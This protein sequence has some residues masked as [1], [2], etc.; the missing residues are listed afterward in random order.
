MPG[1]VGGYTGGAPGARSSAGVGRSSIS[2]SSSSAK[3]R[4]TR[5]GGERGS[6]VRGCLERSQRG[7]TEYVTERCHRVCHREVSQ[8]GVTDSMS[9]GGVTYVTRH[10]HRVRATCPPPGSSCR[11]SCRG[12]PRRGPR[13]GARGRRAGAAVTR[14]RPGA[15]CPG[16]TPG[17]CTRRRGT[18]ATQRCRPAP[19]GEG[20][21]KANRGYGSGVEDV[22]TA[23]QRG[24]VC[25]YPEQGTPTRCKT[26]P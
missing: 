25:R 5:G 20:R 15:P 3:P 9:Q 24:Q 4:G 17:R 12:I 19:R 23:A 16:S 18:P 22:H 6:D 11:R 10:T 13:T 2:S 26:A 21:K 14:W 8:R 7:V 1:M